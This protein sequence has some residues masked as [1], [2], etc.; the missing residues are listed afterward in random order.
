MEKTFS[1]IFTL[2]SEDL[3]L[4]VGDRL[5]GLVVKASASGVE[6]VGFESR[7]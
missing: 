3:V 6:D 5:I 1:A 7:L 4:D 2:Y